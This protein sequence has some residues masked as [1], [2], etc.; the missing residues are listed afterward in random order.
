MFKGENM[1]LIIGLGNPGKEYECTRHN[2][3]FLAVDLLAFKLGIKINEVKY[4]GV[5]GRGNA[6]G[7]DIVLLK[8]FTYMNDSGRSVLSAI[9]GLNIDLSDILVLY[10]D[11]SLPV[12]KIRIRSKGSA[13]G[14]N[15]IKSIIFMTQSEDFLRIKIGIG[16]PQNDDMVD[17]VL[18]RFTSDEKTI[19]EKSILAA[20]DAALCILEK[21]V[22]E[23]MNQYNSYNAGVEPFGI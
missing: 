12:G 2:T 21:G 4:Q 18:S 16:M 1:R 11:V 22:S 6:C 14:H 19:I 5:I 17:H 7:S 23:A 10:D 13:G 20:C 9:K 15:G 8:P 3:G